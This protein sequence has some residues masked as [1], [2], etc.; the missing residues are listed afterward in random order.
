MQK[1]LIISIF[2]VLALP[3]SAFSI[4]P[5]RV[6]K[7]CESKS[8]T[9][10]EMDDLLSEETNSVY[11][12]KHLSNQSKELI[13]YYEQLPE[14]KWWKLKY[15]CPQISFNLFMLSVAKNA[16]SNKPGYLFKILTAKGFP[17][18]QS[19]K[20][21]LSPVHRDIF[22]QFTG[23]YINDYHCAIPNKT[24]R[25]NTQVI[26]IIKEITAHPDY[27]RHHMS[28]IYTCVRE[29]EKRINKY[30]EFKNNS[31][32]NGFSYILN[33]NLEGTQKGDWV[34]KDLFCEGYRSYQLLALISKN[35]SG[36]LDSEI[37]QAIENLGPFKDGHP[38]FSCKLYYYHPKRESCYPRD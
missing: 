8:F 36:L 24:T 27:K 23:R 1:I 35:P 33:G 34:E 22:H 11:Y 5:L 4:S 19:H 3:K 32:C 21:A 14:N 7:L 28:E 15:N 25:A 31:T 38:R 13:Q 2:L 10:E 17:L 18:G 26:S 12:Q 37:N 30:L 16:I 29:V 9:L 20:V 6:L